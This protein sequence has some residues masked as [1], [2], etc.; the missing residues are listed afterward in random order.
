MQNFVMKLRHSGLEVNYICTVADI[1]E[2]LKEVAAL[3]EHV[4]LK[5]RCQSLHERMTGTDAA[6]AVSC[7]AQGR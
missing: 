4:P 7:D 3:D 2:L 6:Y 5:T 1:E